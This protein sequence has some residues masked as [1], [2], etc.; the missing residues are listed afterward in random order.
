MLQEMLT[1]KSY[2]ILFFAILLHGRSLGKDQATVALIDE[3]RS[4]LIQ[5]GILPKEL[6]APDIIKTPQSDGEARLLA[7][8]LISSSDFEEFFAALLMTG[9]TDWVFPRY[10]RPSPLAGNDFSEAVAE[11]L[12]T[13]MIENPQLWERFYRAVIWSQHIIV[14]PGHNISQLQAIRSVLDD[15]VRR[16]PDNDAASRFHW[17][18][19]LRLMVILEALDL[20]DQPGVIGDADQLAALAKRI[21]AA[22]TDDY[23]KTLHA[24][25]DGLGWKHGNSERG[26]GELAPL[27]LVRTPA[28]GIPTNRALRMLWMFDVSTSNTNVRHSSYY[29]LNFDCP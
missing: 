15:I 21:R 14:V 10:G 22:L 16:A 13:A 25:D 20:P 26:D 27:L 5:N 6:M 3:A 29:G 4:E 7:K 2:V 17:Y 8:R 23:I 19:H 12:V 18:D 1:F 28:E 9:T 11:K 24:R